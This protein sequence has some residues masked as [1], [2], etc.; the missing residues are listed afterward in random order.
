MVLPSYE[1][2]TTAARW[3]NC[4]THLRDEPRLAID[5]EANSMYAYRER[6]CLI[7]ISIPGRDFVIDPL[8]NLEL[9]GLGH[10]LADEEVEK[11]FHAAE[12]DLILLKREYGWTLVNLFDTMWAVRILGYA[13]V[14]L[15]SLTHKLYQVSLNKRHQRAN[16]CQRPLTAAQLAYAQQDTHYLL[17]LRDRLAAELL[18]ADHW[19]E[20]QEIFRE[21]CQVNPADNHFDPDSFWTING[22]K[23]LTRQEQAVLKAL[24]IFRDEEAQRRNYPLFKIFGNK[25]LLDLAQ[26]APRSLDDLRAI[27][28]MT[29]G[30]IQRYGQRLLQVIEQGQRAQPPNR[31]RRSKGPPDTV[32]RLYEKLHLWRKDRARAR[33]VESDVILGRQAMW[34]IAHA[35]PQTAEDLLKIKG[36]G[37][38]RRQAYGAEIL[39]VT[40]ET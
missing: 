2:I 8:A 5:L 9:H 31:P 16:W 21:Q 10:L 37:P 12:Y 28:G 35:N 26:N 33:G 38:W 20:A 17:P 1:L 29:A 4:L 34:E 24:Y 23:T 18:A 15:A 30:Q 13:D 32:V 25:T 27:S 39:E 11:V 6:V 19:Q 3:Q 36:L 40:S 14:G 7:Q 22:V